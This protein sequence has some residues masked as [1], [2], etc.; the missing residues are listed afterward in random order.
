M[1]IWN[2]LENLTVKEFWKAVYVCRTYGQKSCPGLGDMGRNYGF[3]MY[4][5]VP[6]RSIMRCSTKPVVRL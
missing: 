1:Y 3:R 6:V 2:F 4:D 5:L